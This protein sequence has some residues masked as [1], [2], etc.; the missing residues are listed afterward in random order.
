MQEGLPS[1]DELLG[2]IKAAVI[3]STPL[4]GCLINIDAKTSID[5]C[6]AAE[7]YVEGVFGPNATISQDSNAN[8]TP[9]GTFV[10]LH[11]DERSSVSLLLKG[12]KLWI[13]FRPH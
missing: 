4:D 10:D 9:S 3:T 1:L 12:T 2:T 8:V 6:S 7:D 5:F 13:I 11:Y